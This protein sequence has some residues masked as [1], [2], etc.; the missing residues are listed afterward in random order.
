MTRSTQPV[1]LS[2]A[3]SDPTGGAGLQLDLRVFTRFDVHGM[4]IPTALVAQSTQKVH[5]VLPA[6]PHVVSEQLAVL[7]ADIV[8]DAIKIG[9][10]ATDDILLAVANVLDRYEI[11]RVLDPVLSASD[12]TALL[13]RRAYG[14]LMNRFVNGAALVTPNLPEA[15][16]LTGYSDP[17]SAGAVFLDAG[18]EAVLIKGGHA[19]GTPDDLLVTPAGSR[20]L[21]GERIEG[22]RAHGTGC[23]LSS[24]ITCGLAR[25]NQLQESVEGAKRFVHGA[26][27]GASRPGSGEGQSLLKI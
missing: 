17:E 7:L 22:V 2:I 13:E 8:P 20:W 19:A 16:A 9:L 12:G 11:P 1:A 24:A 25:G 5:R 3:G 21:R 27:A 10:L 15:E 26:I 23:A 6:F 14:N 18:A 4:A